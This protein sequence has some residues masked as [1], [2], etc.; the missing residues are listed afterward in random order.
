MYIEEKNTVRHQKQATRE[1]VRLE[2]SRAVISSM[3]MGN[4]VR[5]QSA[6]I[7]RSDGTPADHSSATNAHCYVQKSKSSRGVGAERGGWSISSEGV[8]VRGV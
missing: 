5:G 6:V 2:R 1:G 7:N 8:G 3:G 4:G